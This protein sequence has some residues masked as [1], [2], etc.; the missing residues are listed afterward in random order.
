MV[1]ALSYIV[2]GYGSLAPL[3][4][5]GMTALDGQPIARVA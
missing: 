2:S 4:G 5:P 1:C 3:R